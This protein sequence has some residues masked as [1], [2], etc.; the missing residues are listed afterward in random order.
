[1]LSLETYRSSLSYIYYK[2]RY[3]M[4]FLCWQRLSCYFLP[5]PTFYFCASSHCNSILYF[6]YHHQ[7]S[8]FSVFHF[9]FSLTIILMPTL[10]LSHCSSFQNAPHQL[11]FAFLALGF[12]F[13]HIIKNNPISVLFL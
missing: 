5:H 12:V 13:V 6:L 4:H 11:L 10:E 1:M 9:F 2:V 8:F 7:Q 3:M